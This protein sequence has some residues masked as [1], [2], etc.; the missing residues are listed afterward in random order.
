M[1]S[2]CNIK[3]KIIKSKI[4]ILDILK[5]AN[6]ITKRKVHSTVQSHFTQKIYLRSMNE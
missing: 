4:N 3:W 5:K 2:A 6:L 1:S